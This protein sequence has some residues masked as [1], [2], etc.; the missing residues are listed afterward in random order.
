MHLSF[1]ATHHL[2]ICT[3]GKKTSA[4]SGC[5]WTLAARMKKGFPATD[6]ELTRQFVNLF[7]EERQCT[8]GRRVALR[9]S[10]TKHLEAEFIPN[11]SL[12]YGPSLNSKS[13][14]QNWEKGQKVQFSVQVN[15]KTRWCLVFVSVKAQKYKRTRSLQDEIEYKPLFVLRSLILQNVPGFWWWWIKRIKTAKIIIMLTKSL[16]LWRVRMD[17]LSHSLEWKRER[18]LIVCFLSLLLSSI[19]PHFPSFFLVCTNIS[20]SFS[21]M[22]VQ[23]ST[24][25]VRTDLSAVCGGAPIVWNIWAHSSLTLYL[26]CFIVRGRVQKPE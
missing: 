4:A 2:S 15:L 18:E 23:I 26:F 20:S 17:F 25:P 13:V 8:P 1:A 7:A 24:T 16:L 14:Y 9:P 5:F 11:L 3:Y 19:D 10:K 21:P 12:L 22:V 6:T